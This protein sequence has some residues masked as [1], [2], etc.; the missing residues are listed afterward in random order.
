MYKEKCNA[1]ICP[2][3]MRRLRANASINLYARKVLL[4]E[5][6]GVRGLFVKIRP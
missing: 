2:V 1:M 6:L 3:W 5:K 4:G